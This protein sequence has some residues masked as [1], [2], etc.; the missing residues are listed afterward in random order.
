MNGYEEMG[1]VPNST[2]KPYENQRAP[3]AKFAMHVG[4]YSMADDFVLMTLRTTERG[5]P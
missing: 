3:L 4:Q 1:V 5:A 2:H